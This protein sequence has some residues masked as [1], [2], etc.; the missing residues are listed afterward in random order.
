LRVR[1]LRLLAVQTNVLFRVT[2]DDGQKYVLRL[3]V[4]RHRTIEQARIETEWLLALTRETW[5]HVAEPV[6]RM[7]G[8]FVEA[9]Q[10]PSVPTSFPCVLFKWVPGRWLARHLTPRNYHDLG[11]IMAAIHCHAETFAPNQAVRLRSWRSVCDDS[12]H[13]GAIWPRAPAPSSLDEPDMEVIRQATQLANR[14]LG[15]LYR[16]ATHPILLHGDL[17]MWNVHYHRGQLFILD[18]DDLF[19][20]YAAQDI[21]ITLFYGQDR[22]DYDALCGAFR[23]GYESM[24]PWPVESD[25]QLRA[26]LMARR[27]ELMNQAN[28]RLPDAGPYLK[29]CVA[30]LR[31]MLDTP[32]SG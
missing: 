29:E 15:D 1:R 14:A 9:V 21:A 17:H 12:D 28:W 6:A 20:G 30:R 31:R 19:L 8:S 25:G 3:G 7:D 4:Q 18:F 32:T 2:T 22:P 16:N 10:V 11:R 13:P 27:L 5:V 26:L 23:R 24:R